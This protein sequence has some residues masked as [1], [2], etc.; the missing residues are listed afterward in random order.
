MIL[1]KDVLDYWRSFDPSKGT[2]LPSIMKL[3]EAKYDRLTVFDP[4]FPHGVRQVEGTRDP[5]EGR[6][7]LHGETGECAVQ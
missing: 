1:Q 6:I 2:E 5:L 7:V 3:V 4:R